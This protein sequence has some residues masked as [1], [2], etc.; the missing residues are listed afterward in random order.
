MTIHL[1]GGKQPDSDRYMTDPIRLSHTIGPLPLSI[2]LLWTKTYLHIFQ[3]STASWRV[4]CE[5]SVLLH[6]SGSS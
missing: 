1:I 4:K 2:Q 6:L 5:P 3:D